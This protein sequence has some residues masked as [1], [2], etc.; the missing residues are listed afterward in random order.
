MILFGRLRDEGA[1][2]GS[3]GG[4]VDGGSRAQIDVASRHPLEGDKCGTC[5]GSLRDLGLLTLEKCGGPLHDSARGCI[6]HRGRELLVVPRRELEPTL[7][8]SMLLLLT[9]YPPQACQLLERG[10]RLLARERPQQLKAQ[11]RA[12]VVLRRAEQQLHS[13]VQ[14]EHPGW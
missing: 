14:G 9:R 11:R 13:L 4:R 1:A 10:I 6:G 2:L 3:G 7:A 12:V 5:V 8:L